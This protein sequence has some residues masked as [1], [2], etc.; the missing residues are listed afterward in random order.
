MSAM[1]I[2][3]VGTELGAWHGTTVGKRSCQIKIIAFTINSHA[4][5]HILL[6]C[7]LVRICIQCALLV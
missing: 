7:Y 6:P 1:A 4:G 5:M 2:A 3:K